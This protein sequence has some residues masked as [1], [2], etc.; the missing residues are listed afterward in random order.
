MGIRVGIVGG[1]QLGRMMAQDAEG[2]DVE[3]FV[4]DPTPNCPASEF[5][6]QVVGDFS[7]KDDVLSFGRDM[8]IITFEI[9]SANAEALM[10]LEA[11]GK[12]IEPSPKTLG[13]IKDKFAQKEFL[14]ENDIPVAPCAA[15][16]SAEDIKAFAHVHGYPLVLKSRF[17]AY[18]GRGN[19]TVS[20]EGETDSAMAELGEKLYVEA[21]VPFSKELAVVAARDTK[22]T[23][24]TYPVVETV[25]TDH[26]CDVV[27]APAPV[28]EEVAASAEALAARIMNLF[29]GA[30]VF[31][32]EMFLTEE[33]EV[34][35]NEIA[36]R[37]HNSGHLTLS[38]A[39]ISQFRQHLLAV[40]G[41][42]IIEPTLIAPAVVM[43]NILGA[44][45]SP[46]EP[47]GIAEAEALSPGKIHVEIYGKH[48]T[49]V[50]RKMG[51]ITVQAD[52]VAE[53]QKLAAE[54][55]SKISI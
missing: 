52:T 34:L 53:A 49:K 4:L 22:G 10:E 55:H 37:V 3:L 15:V 46:A 51:H 31:G 26:I 9:E 54:A 29:H 1:G 19:R 25:H 23:V 38:G 2:L 28:A 8:D 24:Y 43:K 5:A 17:G 36:P 11:A 6:T 7:D 47:K 27:T 20:S 32:I 14:M 39:N 48:E 12:V 18:D 30:G 45:N 40:I 13:I 41:E 50:K 42:S 21:W 44:R 16:A 33:G 35:I